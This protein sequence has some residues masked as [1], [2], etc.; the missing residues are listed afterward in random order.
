MM[1][2]EYSPSIKDR[3]THPA[4][5]VRRSAVR[6]LFHFRPACGGLTAAVLPLVVDPDEQT[7]HWACESL[8]RVLKPEIDELPGLIETLRGT[9]DGEVEYW[10]ATMIGR[11]GPDAASATAVLAT[12]LLDS[13][14]LAARERAAWALSQIGPAARSAVNSLRQIGNDDP[15]RLRRLAE[16]ALAV[17][18]GKAA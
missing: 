14:C 17:V 8:D 16:S 11:L 4:T 18:S 3:L 9:T 2:Q 6:E 5:I 13:S 12:V 10:T 7:R 15:P 1:P